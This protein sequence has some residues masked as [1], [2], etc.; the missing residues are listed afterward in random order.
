MEV[1]GKEKEV[2]KEEWE[3]EEL[4][5]PTNLA[6][7]NQLKLIMNLWR[8]LKSALDTEFKTSKKPLPRVFNLILLKVGQLKIRCSSSVFVNRQNS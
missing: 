6:T 1:I 2:L 4:Q 8:A 3:T 7:L 5:N